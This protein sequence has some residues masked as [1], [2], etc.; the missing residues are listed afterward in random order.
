MQV[1]FKT[2]P[3]T[4]E[5]GKVIAQEDGVKLCEVWFRV[6]KADDYAD[7]FAWLKK[8]HVAFGLH[9]WGLVNGKLKTNLATHHAFVR[10]ETIRQI[11][12]TI[13]IAA[14]YGCV[15]VNAHPGSQSLEEI[16]FATRAQTL[17]SDARTS[18]DDSARLL[19][20]AVQQLQLYAQTK[21]VLLTIETLPPSEQVVFDA[22]L[23]DQF[24][25]PGNVDLTTMRRLASAGMWIANDISHTTACV[26]VET[27]TS[28]AVMWQGAVQFTQ[29][30]APQTRLLHINTT[31]P[32][33]NGTD[34]HNGLLPEDFAQG[35]FPR[36]EQ[37]QALLHIFR[38]RDDVFVI[39]E[40]HHNMRENTQALM[41]LCYT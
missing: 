37:L 33:H 22:P 38:D 16:D 36:A 40:P 27:G 17:R 23:R 24:Y 8:E 35:A 25:R 4:W 1:G 26:A 12:Q 6:D 2:G 32:P 21:G 29:D 3:K 28:E 41:A 18:A 5:E 20:D 31:V 7:M 13:D 19:L 10:D 15:Y 11:R 34:S 14:Q 39:P 9:H 30:V